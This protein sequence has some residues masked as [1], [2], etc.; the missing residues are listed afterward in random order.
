MNILEVFRKSPTLRWSLISVV[1]IGIV[2][3]ALYFT[4]FKK[5]KVEKIQ[6]GSLM[7][8]SGA[9]ASYGGPINN[10]VKLAAI[11][12]NEAGG[13]MGKDLQ[14]VTRDTKTDPTSGVDAAKKLVNVDGVSAFVGALSSGV[15][16]P[17]AES[18]AIPNEV[19]QISPASTTPQL[20]SLEDNDC[21]FRTVV[22]DEYQGVILGQLAVDRGYDSIS[23][24]YVNNTYG[25]GLAN[26]SA[27][28][29]EAQGGT[30]HAKVPYE[31][32]KASYRGELSEATDKDPDA[33]ILVGYPENGSTIIRQAI[34][35]G[36]AEEFLLVDGLKS[37][38][39]IENVG[40]EN[41]NGTFGTTPGT[42]ETPS[43]PTF[44]EEYEKE[45]GKAPPKPFMTNAYDALAVI[46]LAMQKGQGT[47]S[48]VIKE[49][50]RAVA[51]PPGEKVYA[52]ASEFEKAFELLKEGKDINYQ[53]A[54]SA[55][56]FNK[57]GD[58]VSPIL[59]WKVEDGEI[60]SVRTEETAVQDGE[61]IPAK[62]QE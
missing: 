49:N 58:V 27:G 48:E 21:V 55:V 52:G 59:I 5:E 50:L 47:S 39:L 8:L 12:V 29:F 61:I 15:T 31:K 28:W 53:G 24:V 19:V 62:V 43:L 36:F 41:I 40:A 26:A 22:S 6:V 13:V 42:K 2:V 38:E 14:I 11:H 44:N 20:T 51:N 57:A 17:V 54:G 45:Y 1:V 60:I 25:K 37:P 23:V 56:T 18:V 10:G 9:L 34:S 4:V 7:S 35:E 33:L 32:G 16:M 30:V 46:A 3:G